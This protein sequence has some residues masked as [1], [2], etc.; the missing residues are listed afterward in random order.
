M[1]VNLPYY[2]WLRNVFTQNISCFTS[3]PALDVACLALF[4]TN[5]S[6]AYQTYSSS[7]SMK[8]TLCYE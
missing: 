8:T 3:I 5:T 6:L 7:L 2:F 4:E 1:R